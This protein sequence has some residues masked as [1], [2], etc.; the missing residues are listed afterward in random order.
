MAEVIII[1]RNY[2]KKSLE[3]DTH[4]GTHCANEP[5]NLICAHIPTR[6]RRG[7]SM[8]ETAADRIRSIRIP[9][10]L[11]RAACI[12]CVHVC[13]C[14]W[15]STVPDRVVTTTRKQPSIYLEWPAIHC[16][17][18]RERRKNNWNLPVDVRARHMN[19]MVNR[20]RVC[21]YLFFFLIFCF[22]FRV[23]DFSQRRTNVRMCA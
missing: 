7:A 21:V 14:V 6:Q 5:R 20:E 18:S 1:R 22:C 16:Y 19:W 3:L 15:V 2:E 4:T 12:S 23:N 10:S 17:K 13:V 8:N 11:F 9:F